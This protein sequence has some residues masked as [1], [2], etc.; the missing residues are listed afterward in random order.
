MNS[1]IKKNQER[2]CNSF[3]LSKKI[4]FSFPVA[5][6]SDFHQY[7]HIF[8]RESQD[9]GGPRDIQGLLSNNE[10]YLVSNKV[11]QDFTGQR[12]LVF[13]YLMI[14]CA[15]TGLLIDQFSLIQ[16]MFSSI[17]LCCLE[18]GGERWEGAG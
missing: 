16:F 17:E 9:K 13:I 6:L 12:L 3:N 10:W 1:N 15:I 2:T 4:R 18:T 11:C 7:E 5:D 14:M 8:A